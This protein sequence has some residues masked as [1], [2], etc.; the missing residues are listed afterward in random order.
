VAMQ[1]GGSVRD[2]IWL[3]ESMARPGDRVIVFGSF[4]TV[5]P[6]LAEIHASRPPGELAAVC[7]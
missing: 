5:G 4:H 3:A 7:V 2:A 1:P 6:A